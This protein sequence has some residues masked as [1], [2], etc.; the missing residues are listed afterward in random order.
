MEVV[1]VERDK[2][3]VLYDTKNEET[4]KEVDTIKI[5]PYIETD[6]A[7]M[8]EEQK[9]FIKDNNVKKSADPEEVIQMLRL[10][11]LEDAF[12]D[13]YKHEIHYDKSMKAQ[14]SDLI[15]TSEQEKVNAKK[16]DKKE[17]FIVLV[18]TGIDK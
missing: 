3:K 18:Q 2:I 15:V 4:R 16:G 6:K 17:N 14:H 11:Q 10:K 5:L 9:K 13:G 8:A 1:K 7:M 12:K